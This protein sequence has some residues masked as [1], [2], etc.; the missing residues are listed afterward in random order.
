MRITEILVEDIFADA[1]KI[2]KALTSQGYKS[3]GTGRDQLAFV[4]PNT[5]YVLKIF[6]NDETGIIKSETS[7]NQIMFLR[8]YEF[9]NQHK[10]NPFLPDIISHENFTVNGNNFLR[11][12]T[13]RLFP[14]KS[15]NLAHSVA[16]IADFILTDT[17][18]T[19]EKFLDRFID[20]AA[21]NTRPN[22][23]Y[24]DTDGDF[25]ST[26]ILSLGGEKEFKLFF[27]TLKQVILLGKQYGYRND[28]HSANFMLG[29]DSH[30]VINDPW[31][32]D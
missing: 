18:R 22:K 10:S 7:P 19:S 23:E 31:T 21:Y 9:C 3:L 12:I 20:K 6:R 8:W 17:N 28:L 32:T 13:E 27:D 5:G 4:D 24:L 14:I 11:I 25:A 30:V 1:R 2:T 15:R 16:Y 26:L 29:S